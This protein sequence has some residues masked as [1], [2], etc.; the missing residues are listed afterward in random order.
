MKR[1]AGG[2]GGRRGIGRVGGGKGGVGEEEGGVWLVRERGGRVG[3]EGEV[4]ANRGDGIDGKMFFFDFEKIFFI[5]FFLFGVVFFFFG[6]FFEVS[7]AFS[8][9]STLFFGVFL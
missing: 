6:F 3:G 9:S 2:R 5:F 4:G 8:V 7:F 1:R